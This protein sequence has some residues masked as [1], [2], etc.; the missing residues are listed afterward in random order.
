MAEE[1]NIKSHENKADDIEFRMLKSNYITYTVEFIFG[2]I[3]LFVVIN[4][5]LNE[6]AFEWAVL[7]VLFISIVFFTLSIIGFRFKS[8]SY[9]FIH[10]NT[11]IYH[12]GFKV[13]YEID[14]NEIESIEISNKYLFLYYGDPSNRNTKFSHVRATF[15]KDSYMIYSI[16]QDKLLELKK[17]KTLHFVE[18]WVENE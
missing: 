8:K 9:I 3:I 18:R 17:T 5:F 1:K 4:H 7:Y 13:K 16:I 14:L 10:D 6:K 12:N 15:F 2:S 11:F